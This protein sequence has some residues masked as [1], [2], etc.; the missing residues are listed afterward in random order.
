MPKRLLARRSLDDGTGVGA[1]GFREQ[2]GRALLDSEPRRER[3]E[4]GVRRVRDEDRLDVRFLPDA[5]PVCRVE[6]AARAE[7][8]PIHPERVELADEEDARRADL[9]GQCVDLVRFPL[10]VP[11]LPERRSERPRKAGGP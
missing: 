6:F 7:T 5:L 4:A 11:A 2:Q 3:G 10:A 1:V 9:A 8:L